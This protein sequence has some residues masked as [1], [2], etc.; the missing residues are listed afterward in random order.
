MVDSH[1][2]GD[3]NAGVAVKGNQTMQSNLMRLAMEWDVFRAAPHEHVR[4]GQSVVAIGD[5]AA[6]YKVTGK[7]FKPPFAHLL[8]L[9]AGA[10]VGLQQSTDTAVV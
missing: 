4:D 7:A 3:I 1:C 8:T 2:L 6:T 9:R 10:V 5:Y